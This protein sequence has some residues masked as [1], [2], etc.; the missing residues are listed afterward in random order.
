LK[1]HWIDEIPL[2]KFR[3]E[4]CGKNKEVAASAAADMMWKEKVTVPDDKHGCK[5]IVDIV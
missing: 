4:I 2:S 1:I 5:A 3:C